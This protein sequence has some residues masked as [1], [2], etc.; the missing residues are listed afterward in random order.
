M[1][2]WTGTIEV[3]AEQRRAR[4]ERLLLSSG[5][6]VAAPAENKSNPNGRTQAVQSTT[7][8][9]SGHFSFKRKAAAGDE[10]AQWPAVKRLDTDFSN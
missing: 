5:G 10:I 7:A 8:F 9:D 3:R 6:K 4:R 1:R 2:R